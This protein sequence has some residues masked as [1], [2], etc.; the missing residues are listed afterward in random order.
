MYR[1]Q[2]TAS[3]R[4]SYDSDKWVDSDYSLYKNDTRNEKLNRLIKFFQKKGWLDPDEQYKSSEIMDGLNTVNQMLFDIYN[5]SK[6]KTVADEKDIHRQLKK[7]YGK[8]YASEYNIA[9]TD[10]AEV[11]HNPEFIASMKQLEDGYNHLVS[12]INTLV[13]TP[14]ERIPRQYAPYMRRDYIDGDVRPFGGGATDDIQLTDPLTDP[15]PA[16]PLE[17]I[18]YADNLFSN[19]YNVMNDPEF[20]DNPVNREYIDSIPLLK[21]YVNKDYDDVVGYIVKFLKE[22]PVKETFYWLFFPLY[23][24]EQRYYLGSFFLDILGALIDLSDIMFKFIVPIFMA[25]LPTFLTLIS[26]IPAV[27]TVTAP[28]ATALNIIDKPLQLILLAIPSF[29]K[30]VV[31]I[32]RKQFGQAL[33]SA[34]QM[35]PQL[36]AILNFLSNQMQ[37]VNKL[38]Y[39]TNTVMESVVGQKRIMKDLDYLTPSESNNMAALD[40]ETIFNKFIAPTMDNVPV[41]KQLF[42][43]FLNQRMNRYQR[44]KKD[45]EQEVRAFGLE[46]KDIEEEKRGNEVIADG[47]EVGRVLEEEKRGNN[48]PPQKK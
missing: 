44:S 23:Q 1:N 18:T 34:S 39:R 42:G 10:I 3:A 20:V 37:L 38:L 47:N 15:L 16:S 30:M 7:K 13:S 43:P 17:D 48:Q 27:G 19:L 26:A 12:Q 32:S 6:D 33:T 46:M 2:R 31:C 5:A 29:I 36:G 25:V 14:V 28:I 9:M 24:L 40:F 35:F 11:A 45:R 21:A 22:G 4:G 41:L 8:K